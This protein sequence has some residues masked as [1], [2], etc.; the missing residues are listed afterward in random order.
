MLTAT[1]TRP[2]KT[3][4]WVMPFLFT[5]ALVVFAA[6]TASDPHASAPLWVRLIPGVLGVGVGWLSFASIPRRITV[7][8]RRLVL[9]RRIGSISVPIGEIR[10]VNAS[11]WNRGFVTLAANRRTIF[12]L[13]NTRNLSAIVAEIKRQNPSVTV[14]G[15]VPYAA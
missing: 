7:S 8:G 12:L 5:V 13:R 14:V 1:A 6:A 2:Q 4:L 11:P 9:E 15:G 10:K 3:L